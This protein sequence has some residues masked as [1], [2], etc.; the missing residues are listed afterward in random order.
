MIVE[1]LKFSDRT[2]AMQPVTTATE[3]SKSTLDVMINFKEIVEKQLRDDLKALVMTP[4]ILFK[5]RG[6]LLYKFVKTC[7][8]NLLLN[9]LNRLLSRIQAMAT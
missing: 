3:P 1:P 6:Y 7:F 8:T 5:K 9:S 4:K 2:R